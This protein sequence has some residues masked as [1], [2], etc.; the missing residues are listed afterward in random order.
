MIGIKGDKVFDVVVEAVWN[1]GNEGIENVRTFN[2]RSG[3][4]SWV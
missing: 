3:P 4:I 2:W 1:V